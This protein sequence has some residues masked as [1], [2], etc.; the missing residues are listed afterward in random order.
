[1][2]ST[3]EVLVQKYYV[4][5]R[6]IQPRPPSLE[7]DMRIFPAQTPRNFACFLVRY[8]FPTLW[9]QLKACEGINLP[10]GCSFTSTDT[11][12]GQSHSH[13]QRTLL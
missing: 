1:M 9:N 8:A 3:K 10:P 12:H 2:F 5:F 6:Q 7:L 4:F 13:V 11:L